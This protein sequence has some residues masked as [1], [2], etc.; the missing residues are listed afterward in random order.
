MT[1]LIR[2]AKLDDIDA[3]LPMLV[4]Y[5]RETFDCAWN[6]S[7]E[8]ILRDGFGVKFDF[9]LAERADRAIAAFCAWLP[10]YDFH[11]CCAGIEVIDLYV[12]PEFRGRALSLLMIAELAAIA[13]AY[14]ATYIKGQAVRSNVQGFYERVAVAFPGADCVVG[15]RAF[16]ELAGLAG[17]PAKYAIQHLPEKAWNYEAPK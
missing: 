4:E 16:A 9:L 14:G 11:N 12:A 17:K 10:S 6:G 13:R 15:G 3:L 8:A 5:M 7:R 1:L 2:P